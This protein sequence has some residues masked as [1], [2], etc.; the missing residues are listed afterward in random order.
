MSQHITPAAR[1]AAV[2]AV[3]LAAIHK[4]AIGV[5]HAHAPA[6][7][8]QQVRGQPHGGGFAIGASHSN[9]RNTAVATVWK[10]GGHDRLAHVTAFAER[11]AQVHA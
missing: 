8:A 10:H 3:G 6:V 11:G 7:G 9:H 5:G 2:A 1:S 4:H